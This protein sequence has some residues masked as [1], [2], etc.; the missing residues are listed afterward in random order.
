MFSGCL[1]PFTERPSVN[2]AGKG[3]VTVRIGGNSGRTLLPDA[4]F[5]RYEVIFTASG[6]ET[7]TLSS[8]EAVQSLELEK[9]EYLVTAR[10]FVI[11]NGTEYEAAAGSK[12]I[13]VTAGAELPVSVS[14]SASRDEGGPDGFF[15]YDIRLRLDMEHFSEAALTIA[16]FTGDYMQEINLKDEAAETGKATIALRPGMYLV[17]IR[18]TNAYQTIG[19]TE[20]VHI[21]SGLE[22]RAE[23]TFKSDDFTQI[24]PVGGTA[25][26][27]THSGAAQEKV[28]VYLYSDE[29]YEDIITTAEV[30][31]ADNN[32]WRT[33]IPAS[34]GKIYAKAGVL[35]STGYSFVITAGIWDIPETG[36]SNI[37]IAISIPE[38]EITSFKIA[39]SDEPDIN[40]R[41]EWVSGGPYA[42]G[43]GVMYNGV[44]YYCILANTGTTVPP[45]YPPRWRLLGDLNGIITSA[46][47]GQYRITLATMNW[48]E[49]IDKLKALFEAEGTVTVGDIVQQSGVTPND[50]RRD[51]VYTVTALDNAKKTYTVVLEAPQTTGLPVMKI[52]TQDRPIAHGVWMEDVSYSLFDTGIGTVLSG[53]TAI[54]RRGNYSNTFPKKSYA[55]KLSSKEKVLSMSEHKRWN[56]LANYGDNSILKNEVA[57]ELGRLFNNLAW[58]PHSEQSNLYLNNEYL[59]IYQMTEAIK[60][61]ANRVNIDEITKKNPDGGY[62]LEFDDYYRSEEFRITTNRGIVISCSDPDTDLDVIIDGDTRTLIQ[63]MTEDV[64]HAEDVLY[65]A[66]FADPINGYRKY[67]DVNSFVDWYIVAVLVNHWEIDNINGLYMYYDPVIQKYCMGPLWDY[68]GALGTATVSTFKNTRFWTGR[69]LEDPYFVSLV[70]TRWNE[71]KASINSIITY[72]DEREIY[73]KKAQ[74]FNF[75]KWNIAGTFEDKVSSLRSILI[76]RIVNMDVAVNEL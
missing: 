58:T 73:L 17:N 4:I 62:I 35:D 76:Q 64:R 48:I 25:V 7:V 23:Y 15:S 24:V 45:D 72:I 36:K 27:H 8:K 28:S 43:D 59:G 3:V 1:N 11:I 53:N 29:S 34:Y 30:N 37:A 52:D 46:G 47:E 55:I 70:K 50:F 51:M 74:I 38:P 42:V 57:F 69:L 13:T 16:A 65:S 9:G 12:M 40:W 5:T 63:K 14:L 19:R 54:K 18:L 41:G 22:T 31:L 68:D 21:Y 6:K 33:V 71:K 75:K 66:E 56:L 49:N 44:S 26:V 10:G 2:N 60:I 61:D 67:L 32:T 20:V 39:V